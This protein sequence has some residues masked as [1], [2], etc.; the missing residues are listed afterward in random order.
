MTRPEGA[1]R[2]KFLVVVDGTPES[3]VAIHFASLRA[4]HTD[5]VVTLLAV[6]EPGDASQQWLGVQNI[7]KEEA[8][9]E[10]EQLLHRLA[11]HVNEYAGIR[12]ELIIREGRRAEQVKALIEE[13]KDIAIL[14]LAAGTSKEG[15]GPLVTL[16]AGGS[17]KA[18][19]IP[20]TVVPGD[21]SEEELRALT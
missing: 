14:V 4:R 9:E 6:L 20:V 5:G 12:A 17:D 7:M 11:S 1:K 8:R 13:D 21:L 19:N 15:P 16:V 18:F 10:A 2:R 3:E